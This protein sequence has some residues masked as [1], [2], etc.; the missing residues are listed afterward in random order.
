MT[1][2]GLLIAVV[3][4]A[5]MMFGSESPTERHNQRLSDLVFWVGVG[6]VIGGGALWLTRVLESMGD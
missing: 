5:L 1:E 2:T 3:V 6:L 4:G